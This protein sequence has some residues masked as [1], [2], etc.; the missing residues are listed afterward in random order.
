MTGCSKRGV[1]MAQGLLAERVRK[2]LGEEVNPAYIEVL[3]KKNITELFLWMHDNLQATEPTVLEAVLVSQKY[4][5]SGKESSESTLL[6]GTRIL[7]SRFRIIL[8]ILKEIKSRI[9][10][11]RALPVRPELS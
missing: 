7:E 8:F 3:L 6:L 5:D 11:V 2:E 9:E 1:E 10:A 4:E